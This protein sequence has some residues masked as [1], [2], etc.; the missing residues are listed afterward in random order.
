MKKQVIITV[1]FL[2]LFLLAGCDT[3]TSKATA[4]ICDDTCQQERD[5]YTQ[6]VNSFLVQAEEITAKV[7]EGKWKTVTEEDF[8]KIKFLKSQVF[9]LNVPDGF[10]LI[11]EYYQRAFTHFVEAIDFVVAANENYGLASDTIDVQAHNVMTS[12]VVYNV[13]EANKKLIYAEEEVKFATR[14]LSKN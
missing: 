4:D 6:K 12:Q 2:T 11:Q 1:L 3:F 14:M 7:D 8:E 9:A 13:Q 10:E 5:D